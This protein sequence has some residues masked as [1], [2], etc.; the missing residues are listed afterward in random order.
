MDEYKKQKGHM[1]VIKKKKTT[2]HLQQVCWFVENMHLL[3]GFQQNIKKKKKH[4]E[5]S[6]YMAAGAEVGHRVKKRLKKIKIKPQTC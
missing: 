6:G 1:C 4:I 2:Y 3:V 5:I